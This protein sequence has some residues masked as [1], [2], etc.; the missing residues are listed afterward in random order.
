MPLQGM[1]I[2]IT[3]ATGFIGNRLRLALL[4]AGH[5]LVCA[6]RHEGPAHPRCRWVQADFAAAPPPDWHRLL[7]GVDAV[8]NAAGIFREQ[9]SA[10]FAAVHT[11]G[12][13]ALFD[14]C[15]AMGVR[16]VV[17]ISAL[18]AEATADTAFLLSKEVADSYLLRLPLN[19]TV[20]QPSLVFGPEGA[21]T[22]ALLRLAGA[23]CL[24]LPLGGLQ[25]V[26]PVHVEDLVAAVRVLLA[27]HSQR[28]CGQRV[29]AVGPA[30]MSLRHYLLTL[31]HG[32]GLGPAC[33]LA[34]PAPL[35]Q[36]LAALGDRMP[37]GLFDSATW[38]MLQ[39]GCCAGAAS[40]GQ[41]LGAMQRPARAF[42]GPGDAPALRVQ[43]WFGLVRPWLVAAVA[44]VWLW[45]AAVSFGLYPVQQSLALLE[46]AGVPP[47]LR[48][49][50]LHG[51][52]V[53]D[54]LLGL[55]TLHPRTRTRALWAAQAALIAAYTAVLTLRLPEFWLHPF[56]P[57][58]KNLPLLALLALLWLTQPRRAA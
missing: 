53:L 9:G 27:S 46:A 10:S 7:R 15:A 51:A 21:S 48:A 40:F 18:G 4:A 17:Q 30:P 47:A 52:A 35:V 26:Q 11:L 43:A 2:L 58:L 55:L 50:A 22:Q 13:I 6:G 38:R 44:I 3:G 16:R 39:R 28:W 23:P 36:L 25:C 45:S 1:K 54:L 8:V 5:Q 29:A 56:G 33:V 31:R 41:M 14:A 42:I 19:A 57:L 32:L 20:L 12:P 34:L 24:P 49:A 37:G